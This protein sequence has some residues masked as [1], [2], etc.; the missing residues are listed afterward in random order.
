MWLSF[1]VYHLLVR[2]H[3]VPELTTPDQYYEIKP[4][5][6]RTFHWFLIPVET[7]I[8]ECC[9]V[10][11]LARALEWTN[12][13]ILAMF[14]VADVMVRRGAP[15]Q[16]APGSLATPAPTRPSTSR[17]TTAACP[18]PR[19]PPRS[20]CQPGSSR[21]TVT[22]SGSRG[23]LILRRDSNPF[24]LVQPPRVSWPLRAPPC[25]RRGSRS[26]HQLG[27]QQR[28]QQQSGQQHRG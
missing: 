4:L 14:I 6:S 12:K 11:W 1:C 23:F 21:T 3:P 28:A 26:Q 16:S 19:P 25:Q 13:T 7:L 27:Q 17:S 20:R 24:P 10:Q 2:T 22:T 9:L 18:R 8:W 5:L 15:S